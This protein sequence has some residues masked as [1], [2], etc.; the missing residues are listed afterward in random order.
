MSGAHVI[1]MTVE[2]RRDRRAAATAELAELARGGLH[3][4]DP[5]HDPERGFVDPLD[6][7]ETRAA[8]RRYIADR[9]HQLELERAPVVV[10]A[11]SLEL[12]ENAAR[13]LELGDRRRGDWRAVTG[14]TGVA[15]YAY[16]AGVVIVYG[17]T[18]IADDL[19]VAGRNLA[20][21]RGDVPVAVYAGRP[22]A[23]GS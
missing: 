17:P 7:P 10:F 1:A 22:K 6:W 20:S 3:D 16:A 19:E 11:D 14:P 15:A 5:Y 21:V 2:E 13:D 12:A 23:A 8:V 18:R 9:R 4:L